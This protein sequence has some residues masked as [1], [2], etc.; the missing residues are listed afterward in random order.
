M[1]QNVREAAEKVIPSEL[2]LQRHDL[3]AEW[4]ANINGK[5]HFNAPHTHGESKYTAVYY[6]QVPRDPGKLILMRTDA[7]CPIFS[8]EQQDFRITP[9]AGR[10]Y[11]FPGHLI[12][13][14]MPSGTDEKERISIAINLY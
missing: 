13:F 7:A 12:H 10:V 9:S 1:V 4:W 11:L 14:V 2:G 5:G 8:D 3:K 6:P